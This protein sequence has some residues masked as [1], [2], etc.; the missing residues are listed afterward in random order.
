MRCNPRSPLACFVSCVS[1]LYKV[2]DSLEVCQI[3]IRHVHT[4][5][6]V[7]TSITPVNDLEVPELRTA[8]IKPFNRR[9][10]HTDKLEFNP[11]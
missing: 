11:A 5:A 7:Q 1:Y 10:F 8:Q 4:N 2:V 6:E 3:V 9:I